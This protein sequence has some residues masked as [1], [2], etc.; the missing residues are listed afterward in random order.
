MKITDV[1]I[2][3]KYGNPC[4]KGIARIVIDDSLAINDIKILETTRLFIAFPRHKYAEKANLQT[5]AP[6]NQKTRD[7]LEKAILEKY[8]QELKSAGTNCPS[9]K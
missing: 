3:I 4:L 6:L 7:Q 9:T 2:Q 8:N 1:K 5:I